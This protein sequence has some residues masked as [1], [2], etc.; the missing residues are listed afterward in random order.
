MN[1]I[2]MKN[3]QGRQLLILIALSVIV[4]IG[5][6]FI[7]Y[8]NYFSEPE[9]QFPEGY[10]NAEPYPVIDDPGAEDPF[11]GSWS[12]AATKKYIWKRTSIFSNKEHSYRVEYPAVLALN[13]DST[14]DSISFDDQSHRSSFNVSVINATSFS[15]LDAFLK[16]F[17]P[18][19]MRL[20]KR[21]KIDGY[22]AIITSNSSDRDEKKDILFATFIKDKNLFG[23]RTQCIDHERIWKSFKFE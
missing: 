7:S 22:D 19:G 4:C 14:L 9:Y 1:N 18:T 13:P 3:K 16:E 15:S 17:A 2:D 6:F 21:I 11:C 8:S 5:I 20:E 12:G 10:L 23:I